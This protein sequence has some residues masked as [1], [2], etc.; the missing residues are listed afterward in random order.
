MEMMGII[1]LTW[2]LKTEFVICDFF[3]IFFFILI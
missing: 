2:F 3:Y 1:Q